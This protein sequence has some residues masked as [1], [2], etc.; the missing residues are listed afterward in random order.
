MNLQEAIKNI[1]NANQ[2]TP[3]LWPEGSPKAGEV[4]GYLNGDGKYITTDCE[5]QEPVYS[6]REI[7]AMVLRVEDINTLGFTEHNPSIVCVSPDGRSLRAVAPGFEV[8]WR[9]STAEALNLMIEAG[10]LTAI[11][12][13]D[14]VDLV[15][16]CMDDSDDKKGFLAAFRMVAAQRSEAVVNASDGSIHEVTVQSS[17]KTSSG[18]RLPSSFRAVFK[19]FD[20]EER[21]SL[22]VEIEPLF[23]S[24]KLDGFKVLFDKQSLERQLQEIIRNEA[25]NKLG[26]KC[27]VGHVEARWFE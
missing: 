19:P 13:D 21:V 4:R 23:K 3:V 15:S 16:H 20:L 18:V 12:Q 10:N 6:S 22:Q 14:V 8:Q 9:P 24:G 27:I 5:R 17:A 2:V 7:R 26:V 1:L 11:G 25:E